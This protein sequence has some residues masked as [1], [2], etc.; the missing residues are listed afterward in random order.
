MTWKIA[1]SY[2]KEDLDNFVLI[3]GELSGLFMFSWGS[4]G[5]LGLFLVGAVPPL[6]AKKCGK[7]ESYF[8]EISER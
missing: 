6:P 5:L 7:H 3:R 4:R 8:F 1:K 2:K